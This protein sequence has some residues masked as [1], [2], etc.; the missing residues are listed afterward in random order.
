MRWKL[1]R[2]RL[3]VSAPQVIVRSHLPWPLRWAVLALVLGFCAALGLW[4]FQFGQRIAG[5]DSGLRDELARVRSELAQLREDYQGARA[6]ADT[7][8]VVLRAERVTHERLA[9]QLRQAEAEKHRL[10]DEL[11]FFE[12]LVPS[13]GEGL[14]IRGLQVTP[15]TPGLLRYQLL[16][17]QIGREPPAFSGTYQLE[18]SGSLDGRDWTASLPEGPQPLQ[19]RRHLRVEGAMVVPPQA[20]ISTVRATL[21]DAR[22]TV[23]ATQTLKL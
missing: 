5:L 1:L 16:V 17:V 21:I 20:S 4:A 7:A 15:Q 3:S 22:G 2:R 14:Q 8:D 11:A 6:I 9:E 12:R 13:R 19:L 18:V 23:R 10:Q